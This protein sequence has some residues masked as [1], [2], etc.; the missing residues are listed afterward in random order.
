MVD[1]YCETSML[2]SHSGLGL[3]DSISSS[4]VENRE[5]KINYLRIF[6]DDYGTSET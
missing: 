6:F 1:T 5:K 2:T 4:G 3:T